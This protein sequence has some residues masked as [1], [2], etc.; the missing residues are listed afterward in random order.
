[1][2]ILYLPL[3]GGIYDQTAMDT[4]FDTVGFERRTFDYKRF[5]AASHSPL[6]ETNQEFFRMALEF[7]PDWIHMQLQETNIIQPQTVEEIKKRLPGCFISQWT[8]D[9]REYAPP[10]YC[11]VGRHCDLNLI[12]SVG[13]IPM[14][15]NAGLQNVEY[16]Q[17]GFDPTVWRPIRIQKEVRMR[18]TVRVAGFMNRSGSYP[19]TAERYSLCRTLSRNFMD[20][21]VFGD[22][23][24]SPITHAAPIYTDEANKVMNLAQLLV[25]SNHFNDVERYF[26]DR[27]LTHV[28]SGTCFV[29]RRTPY[30]EADFVDGEHMVMWDTVDE[31]HMK[32]REL[33]RDL[34]LCEEIG[35]KGSAHVHKHHTCEMRVRELV[36]RMKWSL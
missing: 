12:S 36:S 14:F 11:Q 34:D 7:Q 27:Y 16:W 33:R 2:K 28:A 18:N 13:Q 3:N 26:S 20:F 19:G 24:A 21:T 31:C 6:P 5:Y 32:C 25:G 8:G 22:G 17:V 35:E 10:S 23:W 30:L 9:V 29:G 15:V 1:M 4:A